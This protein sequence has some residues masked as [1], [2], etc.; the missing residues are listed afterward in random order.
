MHAHGRFFRSQGAPPIF[1]HAESGPFHLPFSGRAPQL[2]DQLV[3]L[4]KA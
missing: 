3:K 4:G 2:D 1:R